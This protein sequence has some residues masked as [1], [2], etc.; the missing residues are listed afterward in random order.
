MPQTFE[1]VFNKIQLFD[2]TVIIETGSNIDIETLFP[3]ANDK[4]CAFLDDDDEL[5]QTPEGFER[6]YWPE[7]TIAFLEIHKD[8]V[9][10]ISLDNDLGDPPG[11]R[12][13]VHV[14]EYLRDRVVL[15]GDTPPDILVFHSQ[16][17]RAREKMVACAREVVK[18]N[19][20]NLKGE[21]PHL[22]S[23]EEAALSKE[24]SYENLFNEID[25]ER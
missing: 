2:D 4:P 20:L 10:I 23:R 13:G 25:P 18:Y 5:R 8:N 16:N 6:H 15:H 19:A 12:E 17:P 7:E 14:M 11:G 1:D 3:Q 9:G 21:N 22:L 24:D